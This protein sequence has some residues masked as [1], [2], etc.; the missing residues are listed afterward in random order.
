MV[1]KGIENGNSSENNPQTPF[2]GVNY[3]TDG[4]PKW[5]KFNCTEWYTL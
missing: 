4:Y 2:Q 1:L 3:C 5:W